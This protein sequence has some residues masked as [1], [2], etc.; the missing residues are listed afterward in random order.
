[1]CASRKW[2]GDL[3]SPSSPR[4]FSATRSRAGHYHV[5]KRSARSSRSLMNPELD[6]DRPLLMK[7]IKR[8]ETGESRGLVVAKLDRFGRS[9][10]DGLAAIQR[11][12]DANG[13]F[14]SVQ[15]GLDLGTDTG[16]LVLHM[17]LSMGEWELDRLRTS[18]EIAKVTAIRR[19]VHVGSTTPFGY[20]RDPHRQLRVDPNAGPLIPE[21]FRRRAAGSSIAELSEWLQSTGARTSRGNPYW[22]DTTVRGVLA[23]RVYLG[24]AAVR[25]ACRAGGASAA[26]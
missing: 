15:D 20:Q 7:A 24:R 12:R 11:I 25:R 3:E 6:R 2:P 4:P 17:L 21:L 22:L 23:N 18:W 1:M 10:R 13:I 16:K 9:L 14:V 19:G 5:A 8:I 26:C